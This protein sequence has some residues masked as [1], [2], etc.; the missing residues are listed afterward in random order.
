MSVWRDV[1]SSLWYHDLAAYLAFCLVNFGYD[2]FTKA[3]GTYFKCTWDKPFVWQNT[4]L[5]KHRSYFISIVMCNLDQSMFS[6]CAQRLRDR[7]QVGYRMKWRI[8]RRSSR[9]QFPGIFQRTMDLKNHFCLES[10]LHKFQN[11]MAYVIESIVVKYL[12]FWSNIRLC[13]LIL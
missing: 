9:Y 3:E 8:Q 10:V 2:D 13:S 7:W 1:F 6:G 12:N 4:V 11:P 5:K